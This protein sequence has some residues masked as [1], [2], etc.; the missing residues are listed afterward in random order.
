MDSNFINICKTFI[1]S[2]LAKNF[3]NVVINF[4]KR[5]NIGYHTHMY[6]FDKKLLV[7]RS[8]YQT[9]RK[10]WQL[11]NMLHMLLFP[12]VDILYNTYK[13]TVA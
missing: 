5:Y 7:K 4:L 10:F 9:K 6:D 2:I 1:A 12:E 8:K 11:K 13:Y 3:Q